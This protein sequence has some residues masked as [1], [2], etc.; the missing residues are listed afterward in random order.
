MGQVF[1]ARHMTLERM[2]AVKIVQ[3]QETTDPLL[4][5]RFKSEAR[6][7]SRLDHP[8]SVQI[9][10]YGEEDDGAL[11]YIVMELLKGQD[12]EQVLKRMKSMSDVRA[13]NIMTQV[14][15][16]LVAAHQNSIVHRDLKP[17]NIMLIKNLET[18]SE[19]V[20]VCD[21][22]IAK[23][24]DPL[25]SEDPTG[26]LTLTKAGAVVG[27]PSY[28]S[29][30]QA[31]GK[32]VDARTDIFSCGVIL[33]RM[34][35]GQKPFKAET[36]MGLLGQVM[37]T[38]PTPVAQLSST[39]DGRVV[40]VIERAM[41]KDPNQ[42][43]Q[44]ARDMKAALDEVLQG[45]ERTV[46]H[47]AT[48]SGHRMSPMAQS[49]PG[50]PPTGTAPIRP[51]T[52]DPT[53]APPANMQSV[54]MQRSGTWSRTASDFQSPPT[55]NRSVLPIAVGAIVLVAAIAFGV[56]RYASSGGDPNE[57]STMVSTGAWG[58][59]ESYALEHFETF[60]DDP[61]SVD[62]VRDAMRQRREAGAFE[63]GFEIAYDPTYILTQ[64]TW[65]GVAT[66]RDRNEKHRFSVDLTPSDGVI[67]GRL[68]WPEAGL[69]ASVHGYYEGNH[70]VIW[71]F[72][73]EGTDY[74]KKAYTLY[75]KKSLLIGSDGRML[76]YDGPLQHIWDA[77][78]IQ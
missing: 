29:P 55:G 40:D 14:L 46:H 25:S 19:T 69:S 76:G 41:M 33:Y 16:A 38:D 26:M 2:V 30:E 11:L 75:D 23:L 35:T 58:S 65:R 12:L 48:M 6:A 44:S 63:D 28:M 70:I 9:I 10:D 68:R 39:T 53:A 60:A 43:F 59:A 32:R 15:S 17:A 5:G 24:Q 71:D 62:L 1:S 47:S 56:A 67:T 7:A 3:I 4:V 13:C 66:V 42:R 27:T 20:K 36:L 57:L 22:G 45:G 52:M 78:R 54:A 51:P 64:G 8:N 37:T 72:D 18:G 34:V 50:G 74:F 31:A 61:G 73:V 21:F 77:E 49:M